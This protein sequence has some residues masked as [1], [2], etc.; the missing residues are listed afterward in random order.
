MKFKLLLCCFLIVSFQIAA[1]QQPSNQQEPSNQKE[2]TLFSKSKLRGGWGGVDFCGSKVGNHT[3]YGTGG[4]LGLVFD[5]LSVGLYGTGEVYNGFQREN[6]DYAFTLGH[7]GL[8]VGYAY[9]TKKSLHLMGSVKLGAGAVGLARRYNDWNWGVDENDFNDAI[10]V[11]MPEVGLELNLTHWMRIS[12]T[13]G[14][15]FVDGFEGIPELSKTDLNA[16]VFG[17]NFRFGWFGHKK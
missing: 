3:G 17:L 11:V 2:Q 15:R 4:S 14:Y 6:K 9:P 1:Q 16:P 5:N 13:A 10:L 8:M 12:A 7:G